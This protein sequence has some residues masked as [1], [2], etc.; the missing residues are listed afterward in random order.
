MA[1]T[2]EEER[3]RP[4]VTLPPDTLSSTFGYLDLGD[5]PSAARVAR[6]W[7]QI[8]RSMGDK[9]TCSRSIGIGQD[10]PGREPAG[11]W[12]SLIRKH[13]PAVERITEMLSA[14]CGE[15]A[16][17]KEP[18]VK[19]HRGDDSGG[20]SATIISLP[21]IPAPSKNWR[22][23]FQRAHMLSRRSG[24]ESKVEKPK[25]DPKRKPKPLSA[26]SFE[27]ELIL[28]QGTKEVSQYGHHS[29]PS[30]RTQVGTVSRVYDNVSF[31]GDES[32]NDDTHLRFVYKDGGD[33]SKYEFTSFDIRIFIVDRSTRKR[34]KLYEGGYSDAGNFNLFCFDNDIIEDITCP[35]LDN[36]RH[37]PGICAHVSVLRTGCIAKVDRDKWDR[38]FGNPTPFHS[39]E[40]WDIFDQEASLHSANVCRCDTNWKCF[41]DMEIDFCV[42]YISAQGEG[43]EFLSAAEQLLVFEKAHTLPHCSVVKTMEERPKDCP[44]AL[45]EYLCEVDVIL[46]QKTEDGGERGRLVGVV[47]RFF[48]NLD[49]TT[50]S[51]GAKI[52]LAF[53]DN[54]EMLMHDFSSFDVRITV[55]ERSTGRQAKLCE[56]AFTDVVDE[57]KFGSEFETIL[58]LTSTTIDD[59]RF[60]S[61]EINSFVLVSK[62]GCITAAEVEW[63]LFDPPAL[64]ATS[65][66][67]CG[68]S[69]F[70]DMKIVLELGYWDGADYH[71]L[72]TS[73]QLRLLEVLDFV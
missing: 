35:V 69:C 61:H 11:L 73:E 70:W 21:A 48:D 59:S 42:E 45:S 30:G 53:K 50:D 46:Y 38:Y 25:H 66:C 8:L 1:K 5:V 24:S 20:A 55:F 65:M 54:G 28:Y 27:L 23:Q 39:F 68:T 51:D 57:N 52:E 47:S 32:A 63:D 15:G 72:S 19:K 2:P 7:S 31:L 67:R 56:S 41:W 9:E 14:G 60:D 16:V 6:D 18:P 10:T 13:H 17:V 49:F 43:Y 34:A 64:H 71:P 26:Y 36:F 12:L 3:R 29:W 4:A 44:K 62:T 33:L 22:R 40:S 37:T 58:E